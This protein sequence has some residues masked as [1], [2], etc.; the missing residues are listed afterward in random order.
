MTEEELMPAAAELAR[1]VGETALG[2]YGQGVDVETKGDGSPVT[3]ADRAAETVAREWLA[4]RFPLDGIMG[5]EFGVTRPEARRT[6]IID[7]I[8]GTR[9][10]VRNVPL[11][12]SLVAV[13]EGQRVVAGA[14]FFPAVKEIII[15]APGL[16]CWHNDSRCFTSKV[17]KLTDAAVMVTD[18]RFRGDERRT[19]AWSELASKA[20]IARTWGDCY[21]YLLVAT[22]RAEVMVD[23]I[24]SPWDAAALLPIV[25]EAGG[26]FTDWKGNATA[27]GG[28]VIATNGPL[29][30]SVRE[31][32]IGRDGKG[33]T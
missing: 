13:A 18:N 14:A 4:A 29:A 15:A 24:M 1:L 19:A 16:G 5:E 33:V 30:V 17:A 21:G 7:P 23:H 25:T 8:D 27:F 6:W 9:T 32:L 20:S 31:I 26:S 10:F 12:G 28:D 22:G 2:Y 3:I 11:W